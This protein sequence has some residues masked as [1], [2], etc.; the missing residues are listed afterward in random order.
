M[1]EREEI[2]K[3]EREKNEIE[4]EKRNKRER[5]RRNSWVGRR[6]EMK[7][8]MSWVTMRSSLATS[9]YSLF[10]SLLLN[11]YL[12][13][14]ST[15]SLSLLSLSISFSFITSPLS[16]FTPNLASSHFFQF[17]SDKTTMRMRKQ[18][19]EIFSRFPRTG[20]LELSI[21]KKV[22]EQLDW[23]RKWSNG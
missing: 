8:E 9:T 21:E 5:E 4:R 23:G 6:N 7:K 15:P 20:F 14:P 13:L 3:L 2:P 11:P 22:I 10:D 12:S 16:L 1:R 19:F 17:H 18:K